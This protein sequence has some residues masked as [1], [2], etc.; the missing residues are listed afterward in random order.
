MKFLHAFCALMTLLVSVGLA[1]RTH[2]DELV[3][4]SVNDNIRK[5]V[6][7]FTPLAAHLQDALADAG[8]DKVRIVVLPTSAQMVDAL[9]KAEV[10]LYFDSPLVAA[11]VARQAGAVPFLRRWKRGSATYHSV[12]IVRD[13]SDLRTIADLRGHKIGFQEP[14]STSG[15]MLPM[16]LLLSAGMNPVELRSR[17]QPVQPDQVGYLFTNDDKN[18]TLW[19]ARGWIDAAG[20]DPRGVEILERAHPGEFR[21]LAQSVDVPR[22]IVVARG[23]LSPELTDRLR[24]ELHA[25]EHSEEGAAI[26]H[27]FHKTTRFDDFPEGVEETFT[28][29]HDLLDDLTDAGFLSGAP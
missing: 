4:G 8:V 2:A 17:D 28:P 14:D 11:H 3:L 27:H 5:H 23:G 16:G 25:L 21:V 9:Y 7:R 26:L 6:D 22:Q 15:F 10:D 29:I 19:L 1:T 13:D 20:T 24:T 18:T 12:V